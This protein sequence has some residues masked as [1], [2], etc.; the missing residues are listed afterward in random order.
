MVELVGGGSVINGATLSSF[1][2][3]GKNSMIILKKVSEDA[4]LS[5][6]QL[7]KVVAREKRKKIIPPLDHVGSLLCDFIGPFLGFTAL[8]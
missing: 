8:Q 2:S 3:K 7:I 4:S 1:K 5:K 6:Q